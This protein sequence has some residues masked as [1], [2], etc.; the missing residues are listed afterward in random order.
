M[1]EGKKKRRKI[2]HSDELTLNTSLLTDT[3]VSVQHSSDN[4]YK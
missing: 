2:E 3:Y 4:S 1:K